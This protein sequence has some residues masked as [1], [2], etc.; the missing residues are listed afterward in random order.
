MGVHR[1][2]KSALIFNITF[3]ILLLAMK[4]IALI[5]GVNLD[6]LGIRE[7]A[8]YGKT[9]LSEIV[10]AV[11]AEAA[12][13][14]YEIA[15]FQSNYEGEIVEKIAEFAD[16]GGRLP[17]DFSPKKG[18]SYMA[19]KDNKTFILSDFAGAKVSPFSPIIE[20]PGED[21]FMR[22]CA[23]TLKIKDDS[24]VKRIGAFLFKNAP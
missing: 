14:G 16:S 19:I 9:T 15:D 6:R 24:L 7:P 10:S 8:V 11:R 22:K 2:S 23:E 17:A 1:N 13:F 20:I 18:Y 4:K 5:N 21:I 12:K 3:R